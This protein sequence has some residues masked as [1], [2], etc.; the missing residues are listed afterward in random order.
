MDDDISI[1]D[2]EEPTSGK[3]PS[4]RDWWCQPVCQQMAGF[5]MEVVR[6]RA[7]RR[8]ELTRA[9]EADVVTP[10]PPVPADQEPDL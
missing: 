9:V 1:E 5:L 2:E 10:G 4:R 7:Q 8:A 6:G 3:P